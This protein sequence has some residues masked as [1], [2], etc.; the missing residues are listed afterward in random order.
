MS[1]FT[2]DE[3]FSL[4]PLTQACINISDGLNTAINV[5]DDSVEGRNQGREFSVNLESSFDFDA[6]PGPRHGIIWAQFD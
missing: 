4:L 1:E 6:V 2:F 3:V 5:L